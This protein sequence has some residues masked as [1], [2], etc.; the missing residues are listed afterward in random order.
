QGASQGR[1]PELMRDLA[2]MGQLVKLPTRRG[3][4][5]PRV[6][7]ERPWKYPTAPKKS[8]SVA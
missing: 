8:Q 2:S 4:A 7:K 1:I 5:F 6:V 3:R